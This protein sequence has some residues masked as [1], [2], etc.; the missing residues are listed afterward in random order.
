MTD[1]KINSNIN[2][3]DSI[4]NQ[5]ITIASVSEEEEDF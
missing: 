5:Y 2:N 3:R 1:P 4:S